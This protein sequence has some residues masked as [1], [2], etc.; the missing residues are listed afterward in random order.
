M[1]ILCKRS[2]VPDSLA[3]GRHSSVFSAI[4]FFSILSVRISLAGACVSFD[5]FLLAHR[6]QAQA[7]CI[8]EV[9]IEDAIEANAIRRSSIQADTKS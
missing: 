7:I 8:A 6:L 1:L 9:E 3:A 4:L 2:Y 5:K